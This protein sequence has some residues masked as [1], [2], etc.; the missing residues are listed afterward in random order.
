MATVNAAY[1]STSR[2]V[3]PRSPWCSRGSGRLRSECHSAGRTRGRHPQAAAGSLA[4]VRSA[5]KLAAGPDRLSTGEPGGGWRGRS[6]GLGQRGQLADKAHV[7]RHSVAAANARA[8]DA[9]RVVLHCRPTAA[10]AACPASGMTVLS[11][12]ASLTSSRG[13]MLATSTPRMAA[14]SV[15][16]EET[17]TIGEFEGTKRRSYGRSGNTRMIASIA[18]PLGWLPSA[19]L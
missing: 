9:N 16:V 7:P 4:D 10:A 17:C 6:S 14:G 15:L 3:T 19:R 8:A 2:T 11:H 5:R 12:A 18:L 1:S 13:V